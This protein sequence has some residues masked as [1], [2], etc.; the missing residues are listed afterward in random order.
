MELLGVSIK[1][2]TEAT[3][4]FCLFTIGPTAQSYAEAE[5]MQGNSTV[6]PGIGRNLRV[7]TRGV[8]YRTNPT[9]KVLVTDINTA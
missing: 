6:D 3:T 4:D 5:P 9:G 2:S 1:V 7:W 8:G